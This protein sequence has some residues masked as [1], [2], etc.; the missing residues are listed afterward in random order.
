MKKF[1]GII[2]FLII[3]ISFIY[4]T[5][6]LIKKEK[7]IVEGDI[8]DLLSESFESKTTEINLDI[9]NPFSKVNII[10]NSL[11]KI[12]Y[13]AQDYTK[14][15]VKIET[16]FSKISEQEYKNLENLILEN[17]FLLLN[18]QYIEQGLIDATF[19]TVR[20]KKDDQVKAVSCYG[21]LCPEIVLQ[22]IQRIKELW[23]KEILEIGV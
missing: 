13:E 4:L 20:I 18:D 8:S 6:N 15:E 14:S 2:F 5:F 12:Q 17:N 22:I 19:Y 7:E 10:I 23:L 9:V 11:G 1:L 3:I 16:N 21:S